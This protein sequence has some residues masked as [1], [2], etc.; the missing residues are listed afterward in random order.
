MN[1]FN[2]NLRLWRKRR[3][4][5][6]Q[7]VANA[8]NITPAAVGFYEQGKVSPD[9]NKLRIIAKILNVSLD[10]LLGVEIDEFIR[11]KDF[12]TDF[13]Y[14][15]K[16]KNNGYLLIYPKD[17]THYVIEEENSEVICSKTQHKLF[18]NSKEKLQ[19][20]TNFVEQ[21]INKPIQVLKK[22]RCDEITDDFYNLCSYEKSINAPRNAPNQI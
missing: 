1:T 16:E 4:L 17:E 11:C 18:F 12:W 9:A 20:F 15:I 8:L 5:S 6:R 10:K 2:E 7:D 13:G 19:E 3:N 21:K 14:E 22:I